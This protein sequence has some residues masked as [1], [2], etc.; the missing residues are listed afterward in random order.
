VAGGN[1]GHSPKVIKRKIQAQA[2]LRNEA[3]EKRKRRQD[4]WQQK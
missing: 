2:K 3:D 1:K 4:G